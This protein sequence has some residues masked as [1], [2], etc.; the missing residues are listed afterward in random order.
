MNILVLVKQV[1][2]PEALVEIAASGKDL[3]IEPKFATNFFDEFALEEALRMRE[4]HGGTVKVISLGGP[5]AIEALRTAIAMG[6]D[7]ALLIEDESFAGSD[8][9]NTALAL[10]RALEKETFDV[11]LCGR[12]A[13]DADRGEVPQMVA[14]F[15]GLPHVGVVVRL[16]VSD[17]KATAESSL[18][19]AK[20]VIEVALPAIF[21]AQKGLNEPRVPLITGVMKAMKVQIPKVPVEDLGL[22]RDMA[23]PE[24]SKTRILRYL[25]PKKRPAVHL[26]EGEPGE[27]AAEAVRILMDVERVI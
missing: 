27:A 17:G 9:Y 8:G 12:Q 13:I 22:T 15:L 16:D 2:D 14:Q 26:I 3:N 20:E 21:T 6:A 10:S 24:S 7:E 1:P 4:K 18:E 11:V 23:G 19:G 25:P 5:K